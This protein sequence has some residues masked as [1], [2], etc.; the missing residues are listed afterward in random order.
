MVYDLFNVL[1][2][3]VSKYFIEE[4]CI[5]VHQGYWPKIFLDACLPGFVEYV[6]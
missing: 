3:S 5:Y 6:G 4:F 2:D 1:L